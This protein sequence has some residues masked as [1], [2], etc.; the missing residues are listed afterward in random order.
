METYTAAIPRN[1]RK[2]RG[3]KRSVGAAYLPPSPRNNHNNNENRFHLPCSLLLHTPGRNLMEQHGQQN[4]FKAWTYMN[5]AHLIQTSTRTGIA[6]SH[7]CS[8]A[9]CN[10]L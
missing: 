6:L 2:V 5:Q 10:N 8:L 1:I 4:S 9:S 7:L 3:E